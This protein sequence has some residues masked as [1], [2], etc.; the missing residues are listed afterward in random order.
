VMTVSGGVAV[1]GVV[2]IHSMTQVIVADMIYLS[3]VK[4]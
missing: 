2:F 4:D 1:V 3:V